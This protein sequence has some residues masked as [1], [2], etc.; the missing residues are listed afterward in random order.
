MKETEKSITIPNGKKS[1][2]DRIADG[3]RWRKAKLAVGWQE[4]PNGLM[5]MLEVKR[6]GFILDENKVWTIPAEEYIADGNGTIKAGEKYWGA[7]RQ[8]LEWRQT[9]RIRNYSKVETPTPSKLN[10]KENEKEK[11]M[12]VFNNGEINISQIPF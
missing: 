3:I 9:R 5:P 1:L 12:P 2:K 4:T 6:A 10:F 8:Y 11:A 7:S